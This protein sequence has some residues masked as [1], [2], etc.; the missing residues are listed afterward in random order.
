[1]GVVVFEECSLSS[2][3]LAKAGDG[4]EV[5]LSLRSTAE[6]WWTELVIDD[7]RVD[8]TREGVWLLDTLLRVELRSR[9]FRD[10]DG[11]R[12]SNLPAMLCADASRDRRRF[13]RRSSVS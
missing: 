12:L 5:K 11:K 7:D 8:G 4:T 2:S 3:L 13:A 9:T 1:M 6:G 10:S